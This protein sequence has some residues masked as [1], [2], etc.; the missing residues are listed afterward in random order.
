M[1][2]EIKA[3]EDNNTWTLEPLPP[4]KVLIGYKWVY[5][6]K[7]NSDGSIERYKARLVAKGFTQFEGLNYFETFSPMAK[8]TTVPCLL[9]LAAINNWHLHQL[10]VNNAFLNGD[11]DKEVFMK[12]PIGFISKGDNQVC[13]LN[14]SL[15]G[16]KQA[17]QQWFSKFSST[18]LLHGF[19]Q[20][21]SDDSL[22]TKSIGSSFMA[23]LVYVDNIVLAKQWS[24]S[25]HWAPCFLKHS[26]QIE[27]LGPLKF[28]LGLEIARTFARISLC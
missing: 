19:T 24:T 15:Y 1:Q 8:L 16:L 22:F 5:K 26:L 21:K 13:K 7:H 20:S 3:L 18:L 2:A 14:K 11:L 10:D 4:D 28:F 25:Y 23:L 6:V 12:P 27:N 17:S 9:A